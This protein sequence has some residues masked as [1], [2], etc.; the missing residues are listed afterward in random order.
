MKTVLEACPSIGN[1]YGVLINKAPKADKVM[2]SMSTITTSM[3]GTFKD[4]QLGTS[5]FIH[6][7]PMDLE[8][9]D[10]DDVLPKLPKDVLDFV[11]S[12]PTVEIAPNQV[13]P[14]DLSK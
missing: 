2:Q 3:Y 7:W 10:E 14:L 13:K 5:A 1:D 4:H 11:D 8:L 12:V 6:V 9:H